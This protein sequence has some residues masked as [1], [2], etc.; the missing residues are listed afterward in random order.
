METV[1]VLAQALGAVAVLVGLWL[2]LT[3]PWALTASGL[4]VVVLATLGEAALRR[5]GG[6][7]PVPPP[8][9]EGS[10]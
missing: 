3:P 7:V 5:A 8:G 1:L 2:A 10:P 6:A 9:S 4:V